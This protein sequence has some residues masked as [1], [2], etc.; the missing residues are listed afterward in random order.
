M[1]DALRHQRTYYARRELGLCVKCGKQVE[2]PEKYAVCAT[3]R[4]KA[5]LRLE[6][7]EKREFRKEYMRQYR[8]DL[9]A[10]M[11][12]ISQA[13]QKLMDAK[14]LSVK[15]DE[16]SKNHKCWTCVW[17]RWHGDRFFCPLVGCV[18]QPMKTEVI[19][20]NGDHQ[21]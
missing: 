15:H 17:S 14:E 4:E 18:K 3:C 16:V 7:E 13:V 19:N 5:R 20:E 11:H 12:R 21:D 6:P 8:D 10:T 2:Q 1:D 9:K